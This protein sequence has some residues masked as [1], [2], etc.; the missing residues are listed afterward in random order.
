MADG[1]PSK[2]S[3]VLFTT[4]NV[5]ELIASVTANSYLLLIYKAE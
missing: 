4:C 5:N 3:C 1:S 2:V